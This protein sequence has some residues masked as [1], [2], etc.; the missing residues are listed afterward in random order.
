M[1]TILKLLFTVAFI[2]SASYV[3][4]FET[5]RYQSNSVITIRDLSQKQATSS[6]DMIL[7][8]T[9]PVM[10]DSKLLE[11]YI[12][13]G[14]MLEHLNKKFNLSTYYS[15]EKIDALRRLSKES[16]VPFYKLTKENLL[17][18]YNKDLKQSSKNSF[19]LI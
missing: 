18:E 9:S 8:Q 12:R 1:K 17:E 19:G 16:L 7:S 6:F 11:L 14:D 13:S 3:V 4:L 10:Q 2:V 5:E 15:G